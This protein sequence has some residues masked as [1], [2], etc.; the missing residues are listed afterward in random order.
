MDKRKSEQDSHELSIQYLE[1]EK[2][3]RYEQNA[4][5]SRV[6]FSLPK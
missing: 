5:V 1:I 3:K 4:K 2:L 6:D